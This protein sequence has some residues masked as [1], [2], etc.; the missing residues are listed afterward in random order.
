M[1]KTENFFQELLALSTA[2]SATLTAQLSFDPKQL[3]YC[4]TY[5]LAEGVDENNRKRDIYHLVRKIV[6]YSLIGCLGRL[7]FCINK[8]SLDSHFPE[9][10]I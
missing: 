7:C 1:S 6:K 8:L 2:L 5:N 9:T 3:K 4:S 10:I